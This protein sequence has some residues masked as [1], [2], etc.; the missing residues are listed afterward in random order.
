M[1]KLL[2]FVHCL[3]AFGLWAIFAPSAAA[4]NLDGMRLVPSGGTRGTEVTIE[5]PGKFDAWPIQLWSDST[6]IRW[7]ASETSGKVTAAIADDARLGVHFLRL[8]HARSA[9]PLLRFIVSDQPEANEVEPNDDYRKPQ[10]LDSIPRI[11]NGHLSKSNDVDHYAIQLAAGQTITC[12]VEAQRQ[13]R[14]PM[15]ACLQ[16][17]DARGNLLAQN[18]DALGLDPQLQYQSPRD[19]LVVVRVFAFPETPDST[20]GYAGGD[21]FLYRLKCQNGLVNDGE[22]LL[23]ADATA[24]AEPCDRSMPLPVSGSAL[25]GPRA[26][27]GSLE[28]PND[29]DVLQLET[30]QPGHWRIAVRAAEFGS[31]I[32]AV[33]EIF[34]AATQK[35][36]AK[37]GDSGEIRDPVLVNQCTAPGKYLIA[38]RDL[39]GNF[40]AAFRY[41]VE[42]ENQSPSIE[43]SIASDVFTGTPGTPIELEVGVERSLGCTDEATLIVKG[44][45]EG[46]TSEP[47][48]SKVKEDTEKK[49]KLKITPSAAGSIPIRIDVQQT[50]RSD[51]SAVKATNTNAPYFWIVVP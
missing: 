11:V 38:V 33:V 8:H 13:L 41:R 19:E 26:W 16:L 51:A 25:S 39:H 20:I 49:V 34:D 31:P 45:P 27:V 37:Q 42:L 15:D 30:D 3:P 46:W 50:G 6:E 43:A 47:A 29:E 17:L 1:H 14:S 22:P 9:S 32:D 2:L 36:L 4:Q 44:L 35:S 40:G 23:V 24:I 28:T 18:L 10:S 12:T 48:T 7:S 21:K 5:L